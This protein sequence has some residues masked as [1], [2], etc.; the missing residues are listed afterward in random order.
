[1]TTSIVYSLLGLVALQHPAVKSPLVS[2]YALFPHLI[3]DDL[4]NF[5]V[6]NYLADPLHDDLCYSL[7]LVMVCAHSLMV[8]CSITVLGW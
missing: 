1:M 3:N 6:F 8:Q 7:V 2:F 5:R 4:L